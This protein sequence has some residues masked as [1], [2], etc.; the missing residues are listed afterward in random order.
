MALEDPRQH[1]I[2]ISWSCRTRQSIYTAVMRSSAKRIYFNDV[3]L[4]ILGPAKCYYTVLEYGA[5]GNNMASAGPSR[6]MDP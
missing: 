3:L 4:D 5:A 6:F 1:H 2:A